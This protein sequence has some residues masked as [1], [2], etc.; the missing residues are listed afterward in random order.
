MFLKCVLLQIFRYFN[1]FFETRNHRNFKHLCTKKISLLS[2]VRRNE[3]TFFRS[4]S[5]LTGNSRSGSDF[6]GNSG[7]RSKSHFLTESRKKNLKSFRS[8]YHGDCRNVSPILSFDS[9]LVIKLSNFQHKSTLLLGQ[10]SVYHLKFH[11][12]SGYGS[13]SGSESCK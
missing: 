5:D 2:A 9:L 12:G 6:Q 8:V 7:F 1:Q 13:D 10:N 3:K 4:G 11:S